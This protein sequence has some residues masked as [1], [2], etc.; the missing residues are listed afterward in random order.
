M[1]VTP[2]TDPETGE[3]VELKT[4]YVWDK[5][6][7]A[8][9]PQETAGVAAALE[10]EFTV[11]GKRYLTQFTRLRK[12]MEPYT[13]EWTAATCDIP[14]D[15]VADVATQ[16]AAGPSIIDNGVGGIDKFGNN[17]VAGHCYAL[18]ASLTGNY[19]KR[20]TGCGIYG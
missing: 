19:G 11:N 15:L 16:Y 7:N 4:F 9:V 14:A 5:N 20:G 1:D 17:D 2:G 10:G 3:P 8:A 13:L 12:D 18:I 6:A